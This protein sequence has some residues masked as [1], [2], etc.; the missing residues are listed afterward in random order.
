M[1]GGVCDFGRLG[2]AA[3]DLSE[4]PSGWVEGLA[5][6]GAAGVVHPE[7]DVVGDGPDAV[8]PFAGD[9][10]GLFGREPIA[11]DDEGKKISSGATTLV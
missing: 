1:P 11:D 10:G 4:P 9:V 6:D 7:G 2:P 3:V 5:E 8:E